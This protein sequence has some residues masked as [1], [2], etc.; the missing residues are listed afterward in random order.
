MLRA[1]GSKTPP[2][3]ILRDMLYSREEQLAEIKRTVDDLLPLFG[4]PN[5]EPGMAVLPCG[6]FYQ[7]PGLW[8]V[9]AGTDFYELVSRLKHEAFTDER[10]V[11]AI[12][13]VG[14]NEDAAGVELRETTLGPTPYV[15]LDIGDS[16]E[17]T[18]IREIVIG[19]TP[20]EEEARDG[21]LDLLQRWGLSQ[22]RVRHSKIPFRW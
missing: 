16:P 7:V 4:L 21:V 20:H 13:R 1:I 12:Y 2:G 18:A 11:R 10:E 6:T 8:A 5:N 14:P 9:I 17:T 3:F 19:P 22:V 15:Q